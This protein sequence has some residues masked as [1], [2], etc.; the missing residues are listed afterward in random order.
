[1]G[2]AAASGY[3]PVRRSNESLWVLAVITLV[4]G[5]ALLLRSLSDALRCSGRRPLLWMRSSPG[6]LHLGSRWEL[7]A[8]RGFVIDRDDPRAWSVDRGS[9]G[10]MRV[11][12]ERWI[13]DS[14][15]QELLVHGITGQFE[16][17]ART[18]D[19]LVAR[20]ERDLGQTD[21]GRH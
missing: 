14:H 1:M 18:L 10:P 19:D 17:F 13:L 4:A 20:E 16:R 21:S 2:A 11:P 12:R 3:D 6:S 15:A 7:A 9:D 5:T 8:S